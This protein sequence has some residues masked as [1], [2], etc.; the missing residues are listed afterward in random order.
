MNMAETNRRK[1]NGLT[2]RKQ[3]KTNTYKFGGKIQFVYFCYPFFVLFLFI[4]FFSCQEFWLFFLNMFRLAEPNLAGQYIV[5]KK[6][7]SLTDC[8]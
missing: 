2:M 1:L 8:K 7:C 3:R 5:C 4:F 6:S